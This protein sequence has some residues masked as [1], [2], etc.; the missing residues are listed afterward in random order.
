[1]TL[2]KGPRCAGT[3]TVTA[4]KERARSVKLHADCTYRTTV[5]LPGTRKP[6]FVARFDGTATVAAKRSAAA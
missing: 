4:E 2:P 1:V 3:V 5:T 6:R